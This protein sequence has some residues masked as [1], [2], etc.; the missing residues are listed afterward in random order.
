MKEECYYCSV[1]FVIIFLLYKKF[2]RLVPWVDNCDKK[3]ANNRVLKNNR[4]RYRL[5]TC[6]TVFSITRCSHAPT[7]T[8]ARRKERNPLTSCNY[9]LST[10]S[11]PWL[12]ELCSN[13]ELRCESVINYINTYN[14]IPVCCW[15]L[16]IKSKKCKDM[17]KTHKQ[18]DIN[19]IW[20][21][22]LD[23]IIF[24]YFFCNIY[25]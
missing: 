1:P 19:K 13:I 14:E 3:L 24:T 10:V 23:I 5:L 18:L 12:T 22:F 11:L 8:A 17:S 7:T 20:K 4:F 16:S 21:L 2:F 25:C 15:C 6:T 9:G